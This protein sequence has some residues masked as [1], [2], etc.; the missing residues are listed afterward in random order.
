M[1]R[2]TR[3][4]LFLAVL[5]PL[6]AA[7]DEQ[8][9]ST[10]PGP[11]ELPA[12]VHAIS[13]V[14]SPVDLD[15]AQGAIEDY[16]GWY[17]TAFVPEHASDGNAGTFLAMGTGTD[18]LAMANGTVTDMVDGVPPGDPNATN[19][20]WIEHPDFGDWLSTYEDLEVGVSDHVSIGAEVSQ[21]DVIG[22]SYG[23]DDEL[24]PHLFIAT[25]LDGVAGCPY[26][27]GYWKKGLYFFGAVLQYQDQPLYLDE[28][29][30]SAHVGNMRSEWGYCT[31]QNA[32]E[33]FY[34]YWL[35]TDWGTVVQSLDRFD[36]LGHTEDYLEE[37][38]WSTETRGSA[39]AHVLGASC[40]AADGPGSA[41]FI[42]RIDTQA[43]YEVFVS[44]GPA[45]NADDVTYTITYHGGVDTV[46]VQQNGGGI[47]DIDEPRV[48]TAP[49]Y[50]DRDDTTVAS[51]YSMFTYSCA[52][53]RDESGAEV[54]Y[55]LQT[56][57]SGSIQA[58][59]S[60]SGGAELD[61][62]IL[63]DLDDDACLAW[64]G[65][66]ASLNNADA[67][68]YYVVVDTPTDGQGG[69]YRL[70]VTFS[71]SPA[72]D[73][74]GPV[75][76]ADEWI[77]LGTYPFT[78]GKTAEGAVTVESDGD[79]TP[80]VNN[81]ARLVADGVLLENTQRHFYGFAEGGDDHEMA[82]AILILKSYAMLAV[83]G[84]DS[85][86]VQAEPSDDSPVVF[87]AR[88]GQRFISETNYEGW[89]EI[90]TP[91]I[92][93]EIGYLHEDSSVVY[94]HLVETPLEQWGTDDDDDDSADDDDGCK[95]ESASTPSRDASAVVLALA[96]VSWLVRRRRAAPT[97]TS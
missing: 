21:G 81:P 43:D 46:T 65:T 57:T 70:I 55:R 34:R 30:A 89:Y 27:E 10:E 58:A 77:S 48:I 83:H 22:A 39:A 86:P 95:C 32:K 29:T 54:I 94:N 68:T 3:I 7:A 67:G 4:A 74:S 62:F 84:E 71:G 6:T 49:P 31:T 79:P 73:S 80:V 87:R 8:Y 97:K 19:Y 76:N 53:E 90:W 37:G 16:T 38:S 36:G 92:A 51:S 88:R 40:R 13:G 52:T 20:V 63:N 44:W 9:S 72:G 50:S 2:A 75:A 14:A 60:E 35:P 12:A 15:P 82:D 11:F 93:G 91:G 18:V 69:A 42:P 59:I 26:H 1:S 85:W 23:A 33:G 56:S 17:G 45:A 66:Q 25:Y 24:G 78:V 28:D 64:D 61:V 47:G 5:L 96:L 41:T